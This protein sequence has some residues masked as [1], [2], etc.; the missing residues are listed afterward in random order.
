[1][2]NSRESLLDIH[3]GLSAG[4]AR[5]EESLTRGYGVLGEALA[6]LALNGRFLEH[7]EVR[8]LNGK[9]GKE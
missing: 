1:M 4:H 8:R 3:S 9:R 2:P 5:A 6:D 7:K